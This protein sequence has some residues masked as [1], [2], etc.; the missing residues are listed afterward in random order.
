MMKTMVRQAVPLQPME[1]HSGPEIH[2]QPMEDPTLEQVIENPTRGEAI[3]DLLVTNPSELI[4]DIKIGGSLGCS[5][6]ALVEFTVLTDMG[7]MKSKVR[8]LN[9]RKEKFRLFKES[10]HGIECTLSKFVDNTKTSGAVDKPEGQDVI[11]RDLDRLKKWARVNLRMFNKAKCRV[12]HLGRGNTWCQYRL[13]DEG[14]KS[15]PDQG[16]LGCTSGREASMLR[17]VILPLSSAL[18]RP[19]LEHCVQLWSLQLRKDMDLL[20]RVQRRATKIIRGRQDLSYKGRASA[21][22]KEGSRETLLQPFSTGAYKKEGDKLF[23]RACYERTK[24]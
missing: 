4:S 11:Q 20:E 5:D 6:H 9:L 23:S 21:W 10:R 24:G 1:V 18:M 13:G 8:T 14:I 19:H 7:Q 12:L 16:G 17:E 15:S 3:L 22:R 2:L